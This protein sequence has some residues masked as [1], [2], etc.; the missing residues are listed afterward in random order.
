MYSGYLDKRVTV[1]NVQKVFDGRG[2]WT[3]KEVAVG[4]FW[5]AIF[6]LNVFERTQYQTLD[7]EITTKAVLRYNPN[8]KE[9]MMINFRGKK[10]Q[11]RGIINP[12]Y[13]DE[14]MEFVVQEAGAPVSDTPT[15]VT[16]TEKVNFAGKT[17]NDG[18]ESRKIYF[19]VTYD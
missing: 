11:I 6:P 2:G 19:G 7:L 10:Y 12:G 17:T 8:L 15:V 18:D 16:R 1:T 4:E 13:Q 14:Y 9:N 3:N 5:A